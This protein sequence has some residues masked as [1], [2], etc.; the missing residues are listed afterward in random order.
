MS[1][2]RVNSKI[3]NWSEASSSSQCKNWNN[4]VNSMFLI[5]GVTFSNNVINKKE[6]NSRLR[7]AMLN[8]HV[9]DWHANLNRENATKGPGSNKLRTYRTFKTTYQTEIY[10]T[11]ILPSSGVPMI[12]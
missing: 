8:K 10:L 3:N 6:I 5:S 1:E 9:I 4:K 7:A 12:G 2:N 11:C